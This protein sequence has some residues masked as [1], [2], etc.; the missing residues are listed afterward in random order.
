MKI[1][2]PYHFQNVLLLLHFNSSPP[3]AAYMCQWIRSI[4]IGSYEYDGVLPVRRQAIT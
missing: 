4:S 1:Y 3:S 2:L